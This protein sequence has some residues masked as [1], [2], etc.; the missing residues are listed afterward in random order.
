M[1]GAR[2]TTIVG[3][4]VGLLLVGTQA[5]PA[6]AAPS[7]FGAKL[8]HS[9]Q[10][11]PPERC[12][13]SAGIPDNAVCTWV[14]TTAFENGSHFTAPKNGTIKQIKLISCFGGSFR[15]QLA[16]VKFAQHKAKV[17]RNGPVIDYNSD[18]RQTDGNPDTQ[19]GGENGNDYDIQTF[20]VSVPVT[21]GDYV[22][23][24]ARRLGFVHNSGGGNDFLFAPPLAP[25][26]PFKVRQGSSSADLLL[27]LVYG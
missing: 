10:P 13:E 1:R 23:V 14:A 11:T 8:T 16:R 18:P 3:M 27:R 19:C 22:A 26:G 25:G 17:V 12:D 5:V 2:L 7:A 6:S 4:F 21:K 9:S 20:A 24:R 15:L